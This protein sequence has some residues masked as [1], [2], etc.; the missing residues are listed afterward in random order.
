MNDISPDILEDGRWVMVRGIQRWAPEQVEPPPE[1]PKTAGPIACTRCHALPHEPCRKTSGAACPP[2][3]GRT[4]PRCCPCGGPLANRLKYC[5]ECAP[6]V[7]RAQ[8]RAYKE[9][10]A[11]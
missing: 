6:N 3:A 9:R 4:I 7:R 1:R 11:S 8:W 10:Q 5:A 2:H